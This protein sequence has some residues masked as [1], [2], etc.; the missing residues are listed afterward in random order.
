MGD[1]DKT[2]EIK[3]SQIDTIN[4]RLDNIEEILKN[5]QNIMLE[6][7]L[8]ERDI[9]DLSSNQKEI[10]QAINSHDKRIKKLEDRPL[11]EKAG[12]WQ[13]I[14]DFIFKCL[15]T[16]AVTYFLAKLNITA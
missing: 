3:A 11:V 7:K 1:K 9:K 8:Q 15:V 2:E 5:V 12:K 16:A 6:T 13:Y 4:F 14:S 10:L